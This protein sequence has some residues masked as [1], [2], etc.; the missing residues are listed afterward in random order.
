MHPFGPPARHIQSLSEAIPNC[1]KD[2]LNV[3][4]PISETLRLCTESGMPLAISRQERTRAVS[5]GTDGAQSDHEAIA[6]SFLR[7]GDKVIKRVYEETYAA[8]EAPSVTYNDKRGGFVVRWT[9]HRVD[10]DAAHEVV[11]KPDELRYADP[12]NGSKLEGK[13]PCSHHVGTTIPLSVEPRGNYAVHI[14]W[15]DGHDHPFFTYDAILAVAAA[16]QSK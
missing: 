1:H 13:Q 6:E 5:L 11:L 14:K 9:E 8:K 10:G 2:D 4:L 7:L 3:Q 12:M 16:V 15:S